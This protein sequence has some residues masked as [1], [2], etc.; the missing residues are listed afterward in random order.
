MLLLNMTQNILMN[1]FKKEYAFFKKSVLRASLRVFESGWYILGPEVASFEE[2]FSAYIGTKH[3]IGV[4]SGTDAITIALRSLGISSGDHVVIPAN[5]YPTL[6]GVAAATKNISLADVSSETL[7]VTLDTIKKATNSKT[8]AIVLV[9]LYGNPVDMKPIITWAHKQ[10]ILVIEDCAQAD[11]ALYKGKRVG[12]LGDA[13]CFSF[14]PTKNLGAYGDGG[15]IVTKSSQVAKNA[16]LHRMY[17]EKV[18][19]ESIFL[20]INSRLDELHAA[21]LSEKLSKLD[22][23][24]NKRARLAATYHKFLIPNDKYSLVS[25]TQDSQHSYH[26]FVIKIDPKIRNS[27]ITYLKE[28]NIQTGIH[29]PKCVHETQSFRSLKLK[30]GDLS[31]AEQTANQI[32]SLPLHPFMDKSEIQYVCQNINAFFS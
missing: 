2:K 4:A 14:Y 17:G 9:H 19:Y 26:L 6:F 11:G 12:S 31:V 15:A 16:K 13:G 20:G 21:V 5:V 22:S 1:D 27:F 23:L 7:L 30:Q 3:A 25:T 18:R 8:K 29:Y 10:K 32:V 24:N 28:N